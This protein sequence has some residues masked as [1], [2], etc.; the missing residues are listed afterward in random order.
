MECGNEEQTEQESEKVKTTSD[1][2]QPTKRDM[3]SAE[4]GA[5]RGWE[6]EVSQ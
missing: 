6:G 3:R 5:S 4:V 2:G 1:P